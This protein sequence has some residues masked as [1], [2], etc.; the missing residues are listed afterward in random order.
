M[1]KVVFIK[2]NSPEI[3]SKLEKAGFSICICATFEDSIWLDY[4][5]NYNFRYDI[6][7]VGYADR[8]DVDFKLSPIERIKERL[9][10]NGYYSTE[11]EFYDTVEEFLKHYKK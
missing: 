11:R 3:R 8:D 4:S 5:P 7:G 9:A 2:E 1:S 6:H 10:L